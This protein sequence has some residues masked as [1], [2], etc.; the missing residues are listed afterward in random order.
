[1]V[2]TNWEI[3]EHSFIECVWILSP[4]SSHLAQFG[5]VTQGSRLWDHNKTPQYAL[6]PSWP[7]RMPQNFIQQG[8]GGYPPGKPLV[9]QG[10]TWHIFILFPLARIE[11]L[12]F[13]FF[14]VFFFHQGLW[15][16][17]IQTSRCSLTSDIQ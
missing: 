3:I 4:E 6:P 7:Y 16:S 10:Q 11:D 17:P 13:S 1:M 14:M 15:C 12:T 5:G 9:A 8:N 2:Y